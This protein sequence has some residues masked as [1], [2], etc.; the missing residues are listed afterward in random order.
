MGQ[1]EK[2]SLSPQL[3]NV[4][5]W[6]AIGASL[7]NMWAVFTYPEVLLQRSIGFGLFFALNFILY[8]MRHQNVNYVPW[9]DWI[10]RIVLKV[11][12]LHDRNLERFLRASFIG[13]YTMPTSFLSLTLILTYRRTRRVTGPGFPCFVLIPLGT[14][15]GQ[16]IPS[17]F[18]H[19]GFSVWNNEQLFLTTKG[20]GAPPWVW[21]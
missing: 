8:T 13:R 10:L 15:T 1:G 21:L 5:K 16:Y 20:S 9:Y 18:G 19:S 14:F 17:L 11:S 4:V 2:R 7:Y 3:S 12:F 6:V